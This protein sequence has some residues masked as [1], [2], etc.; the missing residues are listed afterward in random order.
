MTSLYHYVNVVATGELVMPLI[1]AKQAN[2]VN[3]G[4]TNGVDESHTR[5]F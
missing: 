5:I 3:G 4:E 2:G 1:V